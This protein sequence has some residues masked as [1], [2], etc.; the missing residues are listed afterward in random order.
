MHSAEL[1]VPQ[2]HVYLFKP[3]LD[4]LPFCVPPHFQFA[5]ILWYNVCQRRE[6]AGLQTKETPTK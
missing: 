3:Q 4:K 1:N 2:N 6:T 5:T